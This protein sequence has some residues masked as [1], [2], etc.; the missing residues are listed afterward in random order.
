MYK[1]IFGAGL[2]FAAAGCLTSTDQRTEV[3]AL[4]VDIP[5]AAD[6]ARTS[7]KCLKCANAAK[8]IGYAI[9]VRC[10]K[11]VVQ[12]ADG[13]NS[14][15]Q[16]KDRRTVAEKDLRGDSR[17]EL[18][19]LVA[20]VQKLLDDSGAFTAK[21]EKAE[22]IFVVD[23]SEIEFRGKF[24][25][26]AGKGGKV[27]KSFGLSWK[28]SVEDRA[29]KKNTY[30]AS[31]HWLL[32][33]ELEKYVRPYCQAVPEVLETRGGGRF[34]RVSY[35]SQKRFR[36]HQVVELFRHEHLADGQIKYEKYATGMVVRKD[37]NGVWIELF[38]S[39]RDKAVV[40]TLVK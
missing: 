12:R 25:G 4:K 15:D 29:S 11:E 22:K 16:V 37:H 18:V 35:W 10:S 39:K 34:A 26:K 20:K 7:G 6:E 40:G 33:S 21:G 14:K 31:S 5:K 2:L 28:V 1:L 23:F 8:Q 27:V 30:L 3:Q 9:E 17:K 36:N 13:E 38:N 24:S 32:A 19:G